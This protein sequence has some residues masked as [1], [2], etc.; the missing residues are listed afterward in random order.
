MQRRIR[1]SRTMLYAA[2]VISSSSKIL[3]AAAPPPSKPTR[4]KSAIS[5]PSEQY[6]Q[7]E[8]L[9]RGLFYLESMYV[10]PEKVEEGEVV[11]NALKGVVDHLDP[12]TMVLPA[13]NFEQMTVDTQGKFGGVGIIVSQ[14]RGKIIVVSPIEDT[15]AHVA[16]VKAGDEIIEID[17]KAVATFKNAD[18]V[19]WMRGDPGSVMNLVVTRKDV[20]DPIKFKLVR[21]CIF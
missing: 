5:E 13:K 14:E 2:F 7:L 10:D 6:R 9:A 3:F 16:G 4:E 1:V 17:G 12:H 15:P 18:A 19:D 20:K 11:Q 8:T 21:H